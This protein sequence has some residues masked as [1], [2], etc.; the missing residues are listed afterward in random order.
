[1]CHASSVPVIHHSVVHLVIS[2]CLPL[3]VSS[4][5]SVGDLTEV[6]PGSQR[7]VVVPVP[8]VPSVGGASQGVTGARVVGA[9]PQ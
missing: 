1:M 8:G 7:L 3:M 9:D 2:L 4:I 5:V 6:T